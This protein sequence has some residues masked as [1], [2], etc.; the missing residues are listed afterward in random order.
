MS[1]LERHVTKDIVVTNRQ[2][3]KPS[4]LA[5]NPRV[6]ITGVV[7]FVGSNLARALL[8]QGAEVH[9]LARPQ[10]DPSRIADLLSRLHL[11]PVDLRDRERLQG[12][13]LQVRPGT[14]F[15]TA[16][17]GVHPDRRDPE[18]MVATNVLGAHHLIAAARQAGVR[19]LVVTGGSSEYGHKS[20]PMSERDLPEPVCLYGA[21][22]AA[23]TL[24]FQ[25]AARESDLPVVILRLFSVYG[26]GEGE[27]RL[28]PTAIRA[29]L[30]RQELRLTGPGWRRDY[31]FIDDVVHAC[32]RTLELEGHHGEILNIGSGG[33]T[34]N[35]EVVEIIDRLTGGGLRVAHGA[36]PVHA[37]DARHWVADIGK[38][39]RLL[40][41][42]PRHRLDDGLRKTIAWF[43]SRIPI[44]P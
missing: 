17:H 41:W 2:H 14:I 30:A 40:G 26:H 42:E 10:S 25:Q 4:W 35:E 29:A 31:I 39:K 7:G 37:T 19:R 44:V 34:S 11:H 5:A 15:H 23:A 12:W 24:L 21:T 6:L 8:E 27:H 13:I 28:I 32:L 33:Q 20:R 1:G 3:Q 43:K 9:G 36:Y 22:K 38:A 16:I 18:E